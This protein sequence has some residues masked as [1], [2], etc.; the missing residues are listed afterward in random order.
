MKIARKKRD[1]RKKKK[2]R[3]YSISLTLSQLALSPLHSCYLFFL[4]K[5]LIIRE[6][7]E[8]KK[9]TTLNIL[10][11]FRAVPSYVKKERKKKTKDKMSTDNSQQKTITTSCGDNSH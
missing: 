10:S 6:S 4:L 5:K 1:N 8:K 11:F 9:Y 3:K 2:D 7:L